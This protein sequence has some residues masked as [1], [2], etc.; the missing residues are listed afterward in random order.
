MNRSDTRLAIE[1]T[2]DGE[3]CEDILGSHE[4]VIDSKKKRKGKTFPLIVSSIPSG[5]TRGDLEKIFSQYGE[6]TSASLLIPN[7]YG[8]REGFWLFCFI[9]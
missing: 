2:E 5:V 6:V 9:V 8:V 1:E 4:E 3:I 7:D